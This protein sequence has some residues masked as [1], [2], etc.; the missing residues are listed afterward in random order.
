M[1]AEPVTPARGARLL[2]GWVETGEPAD[3]AAHLA[4]YGP[5]R[6]PGPAPLVEL[7]GAAGLRGRGGAWFPTATKL[8]AVAGAAGRRRALVIGNGVESEPAS[9]KDHALLVA[10]PHLVLDGLQLAAHAVGAREAVLCLRAGDPVAPNLAAFAAQR[11]DPVPVRVVGVPHRFVASEESALANYL[12]SGSATPTGRLSQVDRA[13]VVVRGRPA[14]VDNVETLAQ[15]ALLARYGADWFRSAGTASAPGTMLVTVGGAVARPGVREIPLGTP[16]AAA[17]GEPSAVP[18][19]AALVGGFGGNWV[20][21]PAGGEV[22][23]APDAMRAVGLSLGVGTLL[24]LPVHAC[25]LATTARIVRYLAGESARQCGPCMFGLPAIADDLAAL[26]AGMPA[27]GRLRDRLGVVTGRGA[28]AHPDGAVRL[29]ASALAVFAAD[30]AA[31][32]AGRPCAGTRVDPAF[33]V[34]SV[35]D[36][37][38]WR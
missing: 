6:Y 4:R 16:L 38:G 12:T 2:A 26:V 19:Q 25:G 8:V 37:R 35:P 33:G 27:L 17:L 22:P 28:C 29:A 13:T 34:P 36:F 9:E 10:T 32:A 15:L 23:L 7:V 30:A 24:A 21:L 5:L 31:H 20:A 18:V 14:L 3:L 11:A 1:T